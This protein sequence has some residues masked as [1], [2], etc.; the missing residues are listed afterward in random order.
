MKRLS[1]ELAGIGW[2]I[3]LPMMAVGDDEPGIKARRAL[4]FDGDAPAF[5]RVL[6]ARHVLVEADQRIESK[7]FGVGAQI[8]LCLRP[9]QIMRPLLR[10]LEIGIARELLRR[11]EEGRAVDEVRAFGIPDAA[12]IA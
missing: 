3:G 7:L 1:G 10:H 11:V 8:V 4:A 12:Y 2:N 5:V 6:G 9:A